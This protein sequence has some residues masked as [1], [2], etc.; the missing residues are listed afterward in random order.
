MTQTDLQISGMRC[1][2]CSAR[3]EKVLNQLPHV[4]AVVNIATEKASVT[5]DAQQT[6]LQ[7]VIATIEHAGFGANLMR[8]FAA[9]RASRAAA[10]RHEQLQFVISALLTAPMLLEMIAMFFK[11][12]W[13]LPSWLPMV[14]ATPVQFGIGRRFYVGAWHS[15]RSGGS[16]MDVLVAL[17][18]SS[19]YFFSLVVWLFDLNQPIYFEASATLIT[20]VLLGKLLEGR[21]KGKAADALE[22]L[23]NLQPSTAHVERDG[24]MV[25]LPVADM[26]TKDVFLVRAGERVPVDGVILEGSSS[27]DEAMLTGESLPQVKQADDKVYAATINQQGLLKCRA[28]AVGSHTQ[29]AAIIRLV[30]QAQGSKA[31]IQKLADQISAVFVPVVVGIAVLTFVAWYAL[32]GNFTIALINAVAVLVIACPCA[33]G[34][35]TPTAVVV[36]TGRAAQAGILVKDAA[37]LERAHKLRVLVVD[38]TG[39]L[40]VGKP[41]VTDVLPVGDFTAEALLQTAARLAQGSTHPLSKALHEY[42]IANLGMSPQPQGSVVGLTELSGQGLQAEIHGT[43]YLLGSPKFAQQAGVVLDDARLLALQQQGKS[44]IVLASNPSP[45]TL[46]PSQTSLLGYFAFADQLRESSR[47]AVTQ[48]TTQGIRVVMLSGDNHATALAIAQQV[49]IT[50]FRAEVLPQDKAALVTAYQTDGVLVGMVGDGINDAPALAAADVSFAMRS[51][52]DIAMATA[53]I[54]LMRNDLNSVVDALSLSHATL[55]KIRQ[56]LFFAFG[57]NVLGIP[58]AALGM[59]NPMIAGAAMAMSSVTVVSN[60]LLLKRWGRKNH[61]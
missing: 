13:M 46:S 31:A 48:L 3:L 39:T 15:L 45:F 16:N 59:L 61:P 1:A 30:E 9:E 5:Y 35:A 41:S 29:L 40:T 4:Q 36:A 12:H 33:L 17:G 6:D 44:V 56:N 22:A 19:A 8:D 50:E 24:V 26:R 51:G 10:F 18:T 53:D 49:G 43:H 32:G 20:L 23:I 34:L 7:A 11:F 55:R 58:L 28:V 42:A 57:Y 38:K 52:S 54:T 25:E 27:L 47:N 37:A 60:A 21:A 2:S 14:L